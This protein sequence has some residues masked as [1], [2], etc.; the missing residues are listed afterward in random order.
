MPAELLETLVKIGRQTDGRDKGLKCMCICYTS[1]SVACNPA[2]SSGAV[3][4]QNPPANGLPG[5]GEISKVNCPP[6]ICHRC[7]LLIGP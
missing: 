4:V 7:G 2:Y 5:T 6:S 1:K 3:L